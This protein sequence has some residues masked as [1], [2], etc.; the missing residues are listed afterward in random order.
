MNIPSPENVGTHV[1]VAMSGGVD[2]SVAAALLVERGYDVIGMML[3]LWS[4][5][6][7][8]AHNR[9]CTP[10][11][12]ELA[13][14]AAAGLGIPFY[15][16]DVKEFFHAQIVQFFVDGYRKGV[17][18]NPCMMCNRKIRFGELLSRARDLGADYLATG[19]YARIRH[20]NGKME[21]LRGVDRNK[22]QSYVLSALDQPQLRQAMFPVG[23]FPKEEVR[24]MA[25]KFDLPTAERNDSQDLCF[26]AGGDYRDFLSRH[27]PDVERPGPIL[28][29]EGRLLGEHRGLAFYTIGQRKGLGISSP[30]PLY[31]RYKDV[32]R[33]ALVVT[34]RDGLGER[35]LLAAGA[36][37]ISGAPP[38]SA[39]K[40]DIQTRYTARAQRGT[41]TPLDEGAF[42][43]IFESPQRDITPGQ[44]AVIFDGERVLGGGIIQ[45]LEENT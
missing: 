26:L 43:V 41:V 37:W 10:Q 3:R 23:E 31:V 39:F 42:R 7:T 11:A 33:N 9:C 13:R 30:V 44:S 34:T 36:H 18:P 16:L 21:L 40:A 14:R 22:D 19:H 29:T 4:E 25:R 6:G 2:S 45:P 15:V 12:M 8:E 17:T 32:Q 24:R 1:V 28:N 5:P 27:A 38:D 20:K 35:E